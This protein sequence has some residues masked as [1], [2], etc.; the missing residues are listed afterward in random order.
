MFSL[1]PCFVPSEKFPIVV[2][3]SFSPQEI[4]DFFILRQRFTIRSIMFFYEKNRHL[5][6]NTHT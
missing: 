3:Y 5:W 4:E 6:Y 2:N 1:I